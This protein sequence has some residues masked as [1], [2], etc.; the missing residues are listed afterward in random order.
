MFP[1]F[2]ASCT[3]NGNANTGSAKRLKNEENHADQ[4]M[5]DDGL[6][7]R[8]RLDSQDKEKN[9]QLEM[10]R[11]VSTLFESENERQKIEPVPIP[12]PRASRNTNQ[13]VKWYR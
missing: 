13:F 11:T 1:N 3:R 12:L 5:N 6:I 4:V 2:V 7:K 8:I 9:I 10:E